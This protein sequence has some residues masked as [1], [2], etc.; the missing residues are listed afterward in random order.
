MKIG[1]ASF[2]VEA[3]KEMTKD[4]FLQRYSGKIQDA[5]DVAKQ[6]NKYFKKEVIEEKEY[7]PKRRR[8]SKSE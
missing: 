6:L 2:N 4:E 8:K 5:P 7:K 3:L 1:T